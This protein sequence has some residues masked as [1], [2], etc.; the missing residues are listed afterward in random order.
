M[1]PAKK[2]PAKK[3]AKTS[4][5]KKPLAK[6]PLAKTSSTKKPLAKSS[7]AKK[8]LA[9]SSSTKKPPAKSS[10]AKKPPAKKLP[11]RKPA[12]RKSARPAVREAA[13]APGTGERTAAPQFVLSALAAE[14]GA[15]SPALIAALLQETPD[16][17]LVERG[18]RIGSAK[19]VADGARMCGLGWT[20]YKRASVEQKQRLRGCSR[21]LFVLGVAEVLRLEQLLDQMEAQRQSEGSQRQVSA[22]AQG[23]AWDTALGLRDQAADALRSAA[24]SRA[25]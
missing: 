5:T 24:G 23:T 1:P 4:S 8:P 3:P 18:T 25:G 16:S 2:P 19:V 12:T 7:S 9:K 10:S 17:E 13:A 20:F 22:L 21:E 11:A 14:L 6:K 15:P